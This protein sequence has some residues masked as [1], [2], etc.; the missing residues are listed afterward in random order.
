MRCGIRHRV[1][2]VSKR[3][4]NIQKDCCSKCAPKKA[5]D[6]SWARR[7]N[8]KFKLA[9]KV[10]VEN[11]YK[12]ITKVEE[13]T[14]V[15]MT[16]EFECPRHGAQ[17]MML[18]NFVRGHKCAACGREAVGDTLRFDSGYVAKSIE[19]L[20]GNKLLNADEY[21]DTSTHNLRILCGQCGKE[22]TT[23][24]ANYMRHGV[25]SCFSCSSK[26]S[27]GEQRIR[28]LLDEL[29]ISYEQEKRFSNCRDVRTLPFDFFIPS[30]NLIIEFDGEQH[31]SPV[32]GEESYNST[33]RHDKIKNQYCLN[34]DIDLLRIPYWDGN[35]IDDIIK[36]KIEEYR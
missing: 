14:T 30:L 8:E 10:C 23:S 15:H 21:K 20:N 1:W 29:N 34:N 11:G 13:Y 18:D 16:I 24:F 36:N 28:L 22:F 27:I 19:A 7:A 2:D 35:N 31:Y 12:L 6:V 4:K 26:E 33:V 17:N 9:E 32:R 5:W 3:Q 25:T